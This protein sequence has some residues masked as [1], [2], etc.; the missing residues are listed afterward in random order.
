LHSIWRYKNNLPLHYLRRREL[1]DA[2]GWLFIDEKP[3][4]C[5]KSRV[6]RQVQVETWLDLAEVL[7]E[8]GIEKPAESGTPPKQIC[9]VV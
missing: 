1:E 3:L 4:L 9:Y 8:L 7:K 2:F 5:E 6:A